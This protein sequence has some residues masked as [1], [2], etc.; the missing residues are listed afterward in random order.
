MHGLVCCRPCPAGDNFVDKELPSLGSTETATV[1]SDGG[2]DGGP[3]SSVEARPFTRTGDFSGTWRWFK[4]LSV[5]ES[6]PMGHYGTL[7]VAG[8]SEHTLK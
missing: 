5:S 8:L 7:V 1:R 2:G 3:T 6:P 4:L